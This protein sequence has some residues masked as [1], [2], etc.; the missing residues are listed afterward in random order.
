[1]IG[2]IEGFYAVFAVLARLFLPDSFIPA[3]PIRFVVLPIFTGVKGFLCRNT[4]RHHFRTLMQRT[5][6]VRHG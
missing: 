6:Q 1:M 2:K 4:K 5:I 3:I